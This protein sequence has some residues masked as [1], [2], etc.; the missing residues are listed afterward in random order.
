MRP[1]FIG[2][3]ASAAFAVGSIALAILQSL[4]GLASWWWPLSWPMLLFGIAGIPFLSLLDTKIF[5]TPPFNS[6]FY[7]IIPEGGAPGVMLVLAIFAFVFW[8]IVFSIIVHF[9]PNIRD[10]Y[11]KIRKRITFNC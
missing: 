11:T 3:G 5:N 1:L 9:W 8:G 10:L 2:F 7:M 4:L 6:F